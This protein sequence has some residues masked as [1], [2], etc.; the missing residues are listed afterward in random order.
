MSRWVLI[1]TGEPVVD[2]DQTRG[3]VLRTRRARVV[4]GYLPRH[5]RDPVLFVRFPCRRRDGAGRLGDCD[6]PR[7]PCIVQEWTE[8]VGDLVDAAAVVEAVGQDS[9]QG[10][11]P[12]VG[13]RRDRH[14][15]AGQQPLQPAPHIGGRA[16]GV[17][18]GPPVRCGRRH[19]RFPDHGVRGTGADSPPVPQRPGDN[20]PQ[21]PG[22]VHPAAT[23]P[24]HRIPDQR[25]LPP[26]LHPVAGE[27]L[28]QI[29]GVRESRDQGEESV[30]PVGGGSGVDVPGPCGPY[31]FPPSSAAFTIS[32]A[33]P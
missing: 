20:C 21:R 9:R 18:G 3:R 5:F 4:V 6:S 14:V 22:Q 30:S 11:E 15:G 23:E 25:L 8:I 26:L 13:Y 12:V 28:R 2:A 31:A 16:A 33:M 7:P 10:I 29:V 17:P 32:G 24:R 19:G 1:S 27:V